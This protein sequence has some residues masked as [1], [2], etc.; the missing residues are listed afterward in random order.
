M[1]DRVQCTAMRIEKYPHVNL[2]ALTVLRTRLAELRGELFAEG[3][4]P[5]GSSAGW[6]SH[7]KSRGR[8]PIPDIDSPSAQRSDSNPNGPSQPGAFE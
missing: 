3:Q 6:M 2:A 5:S 4:N 7:D 1:F 8:P